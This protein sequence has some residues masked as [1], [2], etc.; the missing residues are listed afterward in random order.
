MILPKP[1]GPAHR[2]SPEGIAHNDSASPGPTANK[3]VPA[4]SL[5]G[6][7][8]LFGPPRA[9]RA[10]MAALAG[11]PDR[12]S[13]QRDHEVFAA[14]AGVDLEV[15]RREILAI[16]GLSGS[17]KSTLIRHMNGLLQ[18]TAGRV[19]V[20]GGPLDRLSDSELQS[21]R[22]SQVGMVFQNTSLFPNRTVIDNVVFGLEV[23]RVETRL[24]YQLARDWLE[25]V[26]LAEWA[27]RYPGELSG[28][29][30]QRVGLARTLATDPETLL[31]DEP[32][33][34]LDPII[35]RSLQDEFIS[36]VRTYRKTAVIITHDFGEAVH[37]ADRIG[38]IADGRLVQLGTPRE[39][40]ARPASPYVASFAT[41]EIRLQFMQA[42][43]IA[44]P[45]SELTGSLRATV[46]MVQDTPV[47]EI[48]TQLVLN[49]VSIHVQS[50]GGA[51]LGWIDRGILIGCLGGVLTP[52]L[53]GKN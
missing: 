35:R 37:V 26:Q 2:T 28:G 4:V 46:A 24:R 29:M 15:Q 3:V 44:K 18:P 19:Y 52:R 32:F 9:V 41:R 17:G 30:Q 23:R 40:I 33:S 36:L 34:A 16:V 31:L 25:R 27:D 51:S 6:V 43:D 53:G 47:A 50:V 13:L 14:V 12:V 48:M 49:D 42:A 20:D 7:W 10:A 38:V 22:S 21:L 5:K 39:I 8:K 45:R 11:Q 1:E